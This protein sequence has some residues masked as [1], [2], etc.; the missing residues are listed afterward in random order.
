MG[1]FIYCMKTRT[2]EIYSLKCK[3]T[4]TNKFTTFSLK[5]DVAYNFKYL[6]LVNGLYF[7]ISQ[8]SQINSN[9]TLVPQIHWEGH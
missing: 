3:L 8:R 2:L 1:I 4:N 5:N 9:S 7:S 6:P